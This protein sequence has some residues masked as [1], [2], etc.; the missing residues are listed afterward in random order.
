MQDSSSRITPR[1]NPDRFDPVN[2]MALSRL[3]DAA[4]GAGGIDDFEGDAGGIYSAE[5]KRPLVCALIEEVLADGYLGWTQWEISERL[6]KTKD[7][8]WLPRGRYRGCI[9]LDLFFRLWFH[10]DRPKHS[11]VTE[12]QLRPEME[13][14]AAIGIARAIAKRMPPIFGLVPEFLTELNYELGCAVVDPASTWD[15]VRRAGSTIGAIRIVK[16]VCGAN[17]TNVVPAWY[18]Q[19]QRRHAPSEIIRLTADGDAAFDRLDHLSR[20]W[21]GALIAT[22]DLME[23]IWGRERKMAR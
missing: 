5:R 11:T 18:T 16:Q 9:S 22:S 8:A 2:Q 21:R 7:R 3:S 6:T 4:F 12:E 15:S 1:P 10:P 14:S 17:A 19:T 13:R 23:S 20:N